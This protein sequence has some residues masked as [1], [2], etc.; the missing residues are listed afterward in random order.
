MSRRRPHHTKQCGHHAHAQKRQ[1]RQYEPV[2]P[3][4]NHRDI[5]A[6]AHRRG[7]QPK[8]PPDLAE[9]IEQAAALG[10]RHRTVFNLEAPRLDG[11]PALVVGDDQ[12]FEVQIATDAEELPRKG[13]R[14]L[15]G[16]VTTGLDELV[17]PDHIT[18]A[19][20]IQH[21][22]T[23]RGIGCG[24]R[25][26]LSH[27]MALLADGESVSNDRQLRVVAKAG[28]GSGP[29]RIDRPHRAPKRSADAAIL[30]DALV[31]PHRRHPG[32]DD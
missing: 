13:V 7:N 9:V 6:K 2:R 22:Q 4:G 15:A 12:R 8:P 11:V 25:R 31:H 16:V 24:C 1:H 27:E 18:R 32:P 5:R 3:V 14:H 20:G 21:A 26:C 19:G 23:A 29:P 17:C 10:E 28:G 30:G